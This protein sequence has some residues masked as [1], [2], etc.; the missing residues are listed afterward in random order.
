MVK[1]PRFSV[2][3]PTHNRPDVIGY[4]IRSVLSQTEADFELLVVGDG[5]IAG[6]AD[7]VQSFDDPRIRWFDLPKGPG[8]GYANRN[9]A[10]SE[11][12]G[13]L[14]AH[15]SD[16]DIMLPDHLALIGT[17]FNNP[18]IQ[19]AYSRALWV[20]GDGVAAP[21]LTNLHFADERQYFLQAQNSISAGVFAY[22]RGAFGDT[23]PWPEALPDAADWAMMRNL[24]SRYGLE[25]MARIGAPT[26]LHFKARWKESRDSHFSLLAAWL[27]I[28]DAANWWPQELRPTL[29]A[30]QPPQA[31]YFER[32]QERDFVHRLRRAADDVIARVALDRLVS[33]VVPQTEAQLILQLQEKIGA[34]EADHA[35]QQAQTLALGRKIRG[36][37]RSRSWRLTR[38]LRA[39]KRFLAKRVRR[40]E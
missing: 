25:G 8:F 9:I 1:A 17:S 40:K 2:L 33:R 34:L 38:P 35:D 26:L 39:L 13:E 29:Q 23:P 11:A 7:A 30:N 21:E 32:L 31:W 22:R 36:L 12:R 5:A 19:W 18:R 16:D 10:M 15:M 24:D 3:L 37:K 6:T 14:V 4:A 28:A 27:A 20:S